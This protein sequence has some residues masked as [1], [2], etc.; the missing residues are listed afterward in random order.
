[1]LRLRAVCVGIGLVL[2]ASGGARA[3]DWAGKVD[4][5][6]TDLKSDDP[7]KRLEAVAQLGA[8]DMTL[9]APF[10][11]N[12][13]EQDAA[14]E[15]REAA[16]RAL[17]AGGA[18]AAVPL[19]IL[20]LNGTNK[21][22]AATAAEVLGDIGGDKATAA[23]TRSLGDPETGVRVKAVT[24]LG[25]IGLRGDGNVVIALI[26]RLEDDKPE[27]K[28][29]TIDQLEL[30]GDKRAVIP[31]VARFGDTTQEIRKRAVS[32][33]GKL[34]DQA[35]VPA[36]IRLLDDSNEE[37]RSAAASSLGMLAA[38]EAID[39]LTEQLNN[40]TDLFREKVAI[41]LAQIAA[42]PT[43]GKAGEDAMRILVANLATPSQRTRTQNALRLA[44]RAAVPALVAHLSGRLAGDPTTAVTLLGEAADARATA[45]LTAELERGRVATPLVLKALGATHDPAA[46]VPLLDALSNKDAAI[47]IAAMEAMEPLLGTDA[48]AGDVLI[49]HL[50]DD[51]IEVRILAAQYLG[52]LAD[53][54]AAAKLIA[55][56]K[57]GNPERLRLAAIDALGEIG[58][59]A[60]AVPGAA[61]ALVDVLKDGP[62]QLHR[63][64]ATALSYLQDPA[65]IVPLV[66]LAKSDRGPTRDEVV[67][68]LGATLRGRDTATS[69]AG[70]TARKLL[71]E[72]ADDASSRIADAAICGL[73]AGNQLDDAPLLRTLTEKAAADRR[74]AAAWALGELHDTGAVAVLATAMASTD[75]R[76][77]GDAAWALGEIAAATPRDKLPGGNAGPVGWVERW[78]HAARHGAWAGAIDGSGALARVL[79]ATPRSD[80]AALVAGPRRA[81][82]TAL[83][84][85]RSRLVR[86][87]AAHVLGAIGDDEAVKSL[88]QLSHDSS[89]HVRAAAVTELVRVAAAT[90]AHDGIAGVLRAAQTDLD[91]HVRDA[92]KAPAAPPVA[93]TE[94]A[95][96]YVVDPTADDAPVR[97]EAYFV[98]TAD[99]IVWATYSDARGDITSEHVPHGDAVIQAA[100]REAE[101]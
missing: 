72:L 8:D 42:S 6:A 81:D 74:R 47:R 4:A 5:D 50:G 61:A 80:R 44:G 92:A 16:A 27:V 84:F 58:A 22:Q 24:A 82:V 2:M 98:H 51:D 67:R 91:G 12:V 20:W 90:P 73:A 43:A 63:P 62:A 10:L 18:E 45:A 34:G 39:A 35:A 23:L 9:A 32:A 65:A 97:Q 76:L 52:Q 13:I 17:G 29:E 40:G 60:P 56:T 38:V 46:L 26:P 36:L 15:V 37:V 99:G 93:R 88:V 55:L 54:A 11:L 68:A 101:Y 31:L 64:A 59:T 66:A 53:A 21:Q 57:T 83:A 77:A 14:P 100:S 49:E 70:A 86:I 94:W 19:M 7:K 33:V 75:D 48:R 87:N 71:R 41:A 69:S 95:T 89:P 78:L 3:F 85:H 79:W 96:Y 30:L 1:M 25:K 28:R